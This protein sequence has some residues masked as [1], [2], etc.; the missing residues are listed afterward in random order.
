MRD[1]YGYDER[2]ALRDAIET[3]ASPLDYYGFAS[4]GVYIFFDPENF[5]VLYIG[6]TRDLSVRFAQHNGLVKMSADGCKR[7][8]IS[9]WF[10]EG[11]SLGY[12]AFVQSCYDQVAVSRQT[13]TASAE[14]YD[15][16]NEAFWGYDTSGLEDIKA[17]EGA[18]IEAYLQHHGHLPIWNKIGGARH[19]R[20]DLPRRLYRQLELATG[21]IDSLLLSRKTIRELADDP[22]SMAYEEAL[23]AGRQSAT[24]KTFGI[25]MDS[26]VIIKS[27]VEQAESTKIFDSNLLEVSNRIYSTGYYKLPPPPPGSEDTPGS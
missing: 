13:G 5:G 15:E 19:A 2:S 20:Q 18:F 4:A 27:M 23:H 8:L 17:N 24:L 10:G 9:R 12:A 14:Y 7:N 26:L 22:V 16:E 3:I 6:L 21:A 1:V 11:K 25:G